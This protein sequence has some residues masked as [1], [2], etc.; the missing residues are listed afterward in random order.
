MCRISPCR[1]KWVPC[2]AIV[3]SFYLLRRSKV[4]LL[5]L[6]LSVGLSGRSKWVGPKIGDSFRLPVI[7]HGLLNS[8][9]R[10]WEGQSWTIPPCI[11]EFPMKTSIDGG[12]SS[13]PWLNTAGYPK[14]CNFNRAKDDQG[15]S[16]QRPQPTTWLEIQVLLHVA[17]VNPKCRVCWNIV[18]HRN[19]KSLIH[20]PRLE[21]HMMGC[22]M[23]RCHCLFLLRVICSDQEYGNS[24]GEHT[25]WGWFQYVSIPA[26]RAG[27]TWVDAA[28]MK[29]ALGRVAKFHD[30]IVQSDHPG[31]S[32]IYMMI[33]SNHCILLTVP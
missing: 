33:R 32:W 27:S 15:W 18:K 9:R 11:D 16:F 24:G 8:L 19:E 28:K 31:M 23:K 13:L 25:I 2:L 17:S 26:M 14:Y 3:S 6:W 20:S 22:C 10:R 7:K 5:C 4:P 1:E 12:F 29:G 21:P 30:S